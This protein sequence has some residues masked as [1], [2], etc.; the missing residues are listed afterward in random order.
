MFGKY[1]RELKKLI[2]I[3]AYLVG[4]FFCIAMFWQ[5]FL[6]QPPEWWMIVWVMVLLILA[7][8]Y[9]IGNDS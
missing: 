1:V 5:R 2:V 4:I 3:I 8:I 7:L 9:R 6:H